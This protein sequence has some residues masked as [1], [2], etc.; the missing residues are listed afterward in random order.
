[1]PSPNDNHEYRRLY[2][3]ISITVHTNPIRYTALTSMASVR[4]EV[5]QSDL[6]IG[7]FDIVQNKSRWIKLTN[8]KKVNQF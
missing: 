4:R 3:R 2:I 8:S 7:F 1:M 6:I 5:L